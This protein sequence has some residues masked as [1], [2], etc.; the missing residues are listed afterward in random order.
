MK[1]SLH[2]DF[3]NV[4]AQTWRVVPVHRDQELHW[5]DPGGFLLA[6]SPA[7]KEWQPD[8]MYD[9]DFQ[10]N[11]LEQSIMAKRYIDL[12]GSNQ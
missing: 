7:P 4:A 12:A 3:G 9:Y 2:R 8:F 6:I 1:A 11:P 5:Y 10:L